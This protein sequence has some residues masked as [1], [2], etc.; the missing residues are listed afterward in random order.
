MSGSRP[1]IAM[2]SPDPGTVLKLPAANRKSRHI[3]LSL[4]PPFAVIPNP[5]FG[6]VA[7][8]AAPNASLALLV[9]PLLGNTD[10]GNGC[11]LW[12]DVTASLTLASATADSQGLARIAV[13]VPSDPSLEGATLVFQA[14]ELVTGGPVFGAFELS[15]GLRVQ[16]GNQTTGCR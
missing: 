9:S 6:L 4:P 3:E 14:V 7:E 11:T 1:V 2:R 5:T 13:P 15:N 16:I 12:L 8:D 10:L